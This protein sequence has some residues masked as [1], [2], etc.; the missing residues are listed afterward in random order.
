MAKFHTKFHPEI[1]TFNFLSPLTLL[2][3][4][5]SFFLVEISFDKDFYIVLKICTCLAKDG[6]SHFFTK[7][8]FFFTMHSLLLP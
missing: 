8:F 2:L 3:L 5:S 6:K 4:G 7:L 1:N